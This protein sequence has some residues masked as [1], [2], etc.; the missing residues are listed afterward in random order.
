[1]FEPR[2]TVRVLERAD[3]GGEEAQ[4]I[5]GPKGLQ[6]IVIVDRKAGEVRG[7]VRSFVSHT[8]ARPICDASYIYCA[9]WA[10]ASTVRARFRRMKQAFSEGATGGTDW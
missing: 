8:F 1:M 3:I 4:R 7:L 10:P 6:A 2:F 9:S 5:A